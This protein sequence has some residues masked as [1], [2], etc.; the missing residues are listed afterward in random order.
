[1]SLAVGHSL[2]REF[3]RMGFLR[4]TPGLHPGSRS[5]KTNYYAAGK[6]DRHQYTSG[7]SF[8]VRRA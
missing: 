4:S 1:M 2:S 6:V 7:I 8:F 5:A 3:G